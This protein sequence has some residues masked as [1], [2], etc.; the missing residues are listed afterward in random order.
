MKETYDAGL[1]PYRSEYM[2][3]GRMIEFI[4]INIK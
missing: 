4:K 3:I 1:I 2:R